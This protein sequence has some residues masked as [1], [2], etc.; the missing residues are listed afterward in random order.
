MIINKVV[1]QNFMC[2]YDKK[3]FNFSD[4]LNIIIGENGEGKTKFF[5]A[6]EWF[7]DE[8][9][10]GTIPELE[11]LISSKKKDEIEVSNK[12]EVAVEIEL[13][14]FDELKKLKRHFYVT[15]IDSDKFQFSG[16]N[17]SASID[18]VN[19]TTENINTD[20]ILHNI[21]PIQVRQFSMF[22]GEQKFKILE[23]KDHLNEL[24]NNFSDT[25]EYE[26]ILKMVNELIKYKGSAIRKDTQKKNED[27]KKI[28]I[29]E[30]DINSKLEEKENI[31]K[32]LIVRLDEIDKIT[33]D[34]ERHERLVD[35]YENIK[36][37]KDDIN[38][39]NKEIYEKRL[40]IN[41]DY[42][43]M[44][45]DKKWILKNFH[46]I[47]KEYSSKIESISK[48]KRDNEF[49]HN[50]RQ[51]EEVAKENIMLAIKSKLPFDVPSV[52]I[53][54]DM[55][56]QEICFVC[57]RKAEK[58][59]E[60]HNFMKTRLEE[61]ERKV[62]EGAKKRKLTELYPNNYLRNLTSIWQTHVDSLESVSDIEQAKLESLKE[63]RRVE[64][65]IKNLEKELETLENKMKEVTLSSNVSEED[66]LHNLFTY[67]ENIKKVTVNTIIIDKKRES[68][69][70]ID[71]GLKDKQLE[72][73]N[74]TKSKN[75]ILN[76]TLDR[77]KKISD[78]IK[79]TRDK[80]FD[81]FF[82]KLE[83]E[84]NEIFK[85]IN[86]DSFTGYIQLEKI[87]KEIKFE[88]RVNLMENEKKF[89][90]P[91]E[92]LKTSMHI[93][94]LFAVSKMYRE[95]N[96]D[97]YPVILDAPTSTFGESKTKNFL[98]T[99]SDVGSQKILLI[100]DFITRDDEGNFKIKDEFSLIHRKKSFW[101]RL[102]RPFDS[103]KLNT[104][105]TLVEE[106]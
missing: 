26:K 44:L 58:E 104:I 106:I 42:T 28:K 105:N 9:I 57:N 87:T 4:G 32:E 91:N 3:V 35:N 6:I 45:F 25:I 83:T 93:A 102:E 66:S 10:D 103:K 23:N 24:L 73:D 70:E 96:E 77:Y 37:I 84:T 64:D 12:F 15:K 97:D 33:A 75:L 2:Y 11:Y 18:K 46:P 69:K 80:V 27:I 98:N 55:I 74:Y 79:D 100:K 56:D 40:N 89:E 16:V 21:F 94:I 86:V 49:E 20:T 29:L 76:E 81:D 72:L 34:I 38:R 17:F 101:I 90:N 95:L 51:I 78:I 61:F 52:D 5:E 50:T 43:K 19:G 82:K 22:K 99:L 1:L 65:E 60:P 71:R 63:N 59:T 54:K 68:I 31:E 8:K 47:L 62:N 67:K 7:F 85:K 13:K 88:V 53:M 30:D 48:T 92:S 41:T 36:H 39:I 14:Q